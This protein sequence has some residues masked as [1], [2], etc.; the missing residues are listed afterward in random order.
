VWIN[1]WNVRDLD[2]PFGGVKNRIGAR[3]MAGDGVFT[4]EKTVRALHQSEPRGLP[5]WNTRVPRG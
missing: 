5:R 4:D 2:T 3:A 1:C